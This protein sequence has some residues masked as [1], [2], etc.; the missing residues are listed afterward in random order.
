VLKLRS[1]VQC[2]IKKSTFLLLL[3][4]K[5]NI[6]PDTLIKILLNK[7]KYY[8]SFDIPKADGS[9]R[10]ITPSLAPLKS[11]QGTAKLFIDSILK[12]P[13]YLHG[14][15]PRR[16]VLTNVKVHVGRYMVTNLDVRK[17][18]PNT[19]G[20][21]VREALCDI[22]F[23]DE[24]AELITDICIY[25]DCL[26][27]GAPTSTNIVNIVL[28]KID[29]NLY[30]YCKRHKFKYTRFVDDITIS[31]DCDLRGYKNK[32]SDGIL[33]VG[34]KISKY[35]ALPKTKAQVVTGLTVNRQ[36][37]PTKA[38]LKQLKDDIKSGWPENDMMQ[39]TA[40]MYGLTMNQLRANIWGRINFVKSINKKHGR[41]MRSLMTKVLWRN[42]D[43]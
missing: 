1:S 42:K 31:A 26:P 37:R 40:D 9:T 23:S 16:S 14:G 21:M 35:S 34:Y 2:P 38:Y 5:L 25:K 24:L 6:K 20:E 19:S 8:Y 10:I 36:A 27:Q 30:Y 32:F 17:C 22:G 28:N 3:D 4:K 29:R 11:I 33:A 12:W 13:A 15:I 41:Q 18:F 43:Q 7:S 39:L